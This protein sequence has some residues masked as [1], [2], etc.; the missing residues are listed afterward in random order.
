MQNQPEPVAAAPRIG[1]AFGYAGPERL[2][3]RAWCLYHSTSR[4][5]RAQEDCVRDAGTPPAHLAQDFRV[6][7]RF[8][9]EGNCPVK[10]VMTSVGFDDLL[11]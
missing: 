2:A 10:M 4:G 3:Y 7:R 1:Q 8:A 6:I 11:Q 9:C 5:L